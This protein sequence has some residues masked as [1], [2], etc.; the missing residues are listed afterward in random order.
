[1]MREKF[2]TA[3]VPA[4]FALLLS[5]TACG[6]AGG[7]EITEEFDQTYDAATIKFLKLENRNGNVELEVWDRVEIQVKAIKR[8]RSLREKQ[9]E[10]RLK[11]IKIVVTP[12]EDTL[13]IRTVW[14]K[15]RRGFQFFSGGRSASVHYQLKLPRQL[16]VDARTSNGRLNAS[17]LEGDQLFRSTNG[18]IEVQ[19][20]SG[21]LEAK[22]TNGRINV[23]GASGRV[24]LL[25][26]KGTIRANNLKGSIRAKTTNG[27]IRASFQ[28]SPEDEVNLGTTNGSIRLTLPAG[29]N[30]DLLARTT[31]GSVTTEFPVMMRVE[32]EIKKRPKRVEGKLGSGG[33]LL[34]LS[35]TNGSIRILKST[36]NGEVEAEGESAPSEN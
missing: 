13:T 20:V 1:M 12:S 2:R 31:N 6:I 30:A 9:A 22:T 10:E 18:R 14:P 35:T 32:G 16:N 5:A 15:R 23:T 36:E 29:T 8:V 4:L 19:E 33:V 26:T 25:T 28:D 17:G 3:V 7:F 11:V 21:T 34:D 27:S 24:N